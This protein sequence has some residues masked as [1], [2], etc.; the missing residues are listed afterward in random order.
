LLAYDD[1]HLVKALMHNKGRK[2]IS[3]YMQHTLQKTTVQSIL[4]FGSET[5][6]LS[7]SN[8]KLL[9]GFHIKRLM[10][11]LDGTWA[12]PNLAQVLKNIGL[13]I[14]AHYIAA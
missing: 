2:C 10:K 7:P 8:L 1:H 5:W 11:L 14:I 6:N 12:Y 13:K 9:E 4:L 3:P